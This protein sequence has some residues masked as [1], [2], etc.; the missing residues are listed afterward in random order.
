MI[1]DDMMTFVR[2]DL[3]L[4]GTAMSLMLLLALKLLFRR[5]RWVVLPMLC[6]ATSVTIMMG[7][8]GHLGWPVTV[9]SSNFI[10]LQLILTLAL[11]IHLVVRFTEL[12]RNAPETDQQ[13]VIESTVT[14]KFIPCL[15]TT[16]TTI[17]GFSSLVMS[18]ILP[19]IDFGWMMA[20]GL[21][22]S[23][24]VTFL[25]FPAGL[26]LMKPLSARSEGTPGS[27]F[28]A[29]LAGLADRRQRLV[30]GA[31]LLMV[32]GTVAGIWQLRVENSFI[33]YFRKSTAIYQGMKVIDDHLGG[34]TPLDIVVNFGA[35]EARAGLTPPN[36]EE[37][38]D[39]DEVPAASSGPEES[40]GFDE[41]AE[42]EV[43]REFDEPAEKAKY[44]FTGERIQT[45]RDV[46]LYLEN[47]PA[48]GNVLS[49]DS[50]V[51]VAE[52]L[53]GGE[54]LDNFSLAVF[55]NNLGK[56]G[57]ADLV[58][59]YASIEHD[60]ARVSARIRDSLPGLNRK[61]FLE[62]VTADL[63]GELGLGGRVQIAG[64]MVLYD[65][66]LQS[67]FASQI[68]TAGT[69]M[70]LLWFM[71]LLL[72]RSV[73]IASI[74]LVPNLIASLAVLGVMGWLDLPLDMMTITV[75]AISIGIAIDHTIHYCHRFQQ[76][77]LV[78]GDYHAAMFRS[79][80][81]VGSALLYTSTTIII[82]FSILALS[83][84]IPSVIFGLLTALAM[85][86][87]PIASLTLLPV[88]ILRIRPF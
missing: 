34:T 59:P 54:P 77:L 5:W 67:L 72:F 70:L 45:I 82:G 3:Q 38:S 13:D 32:A 40:D 63:N 86:L 36:V 66:M 22:I 73:K 60:Q 24:C 52:E 4:F 55:F 88:L 56:D 14:T 51:R 62:K 71:I 74:A 6:C 58:D 44:W 8:L 27:G 84:F 15:F 49:L 39:P 80:Q 10:S 61:E 81:S 7:L 50:T 20:L 65:N 41:F 47:L 69:T 16:L 33:D 12:R 19:V 11:S 17:A 25:L 53:T 48:V 29:A 28:T 43:F 23:L 35:A 79:H 21:V 68:Q 85:A 64:L 30:L 37:I 1:A 42:F 87:A 76:E 31:S 46:H 9:I 18:D 26:A 83:N 78:D 75:V 57:R 2:K